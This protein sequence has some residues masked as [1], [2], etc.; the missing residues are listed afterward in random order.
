MTN[1]WCI[2]RSSLWRTTGRQAD[3]LM[4]VPAKYSWTE[5]KQLTANRDYYWRSRVNT[6]R[7]GTGVSVNHSWSPPIPVQT[8]IQQ[9]QQQPNHQID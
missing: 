4:D 5:L 3:L 2:K 6:I 8:Q 1:A 7:E 9:A